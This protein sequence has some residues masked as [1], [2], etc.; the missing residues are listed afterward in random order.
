MRPCSLPMGATALRYCADP[1]WLA[2]PKL[3]GVRCLLAVLEDGCHAWSRQLRPL[4]L[5]PAVEEAARA[6]LPDGAIL[7]C[8]LMKDGTLVAFDVPVLRHTLERRLSMLEEL[9]PHDGPLRLIPAVQF[10]PGV[11]LWVAAMLAGHEGIVLKRRDSMYQWASGPDDETSA[12]MKVRA[13]KA[14]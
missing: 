4:R 5:R 7:D 3:D 2:Q 6:L 10:L 1:R 8:E 14:R 11:P 12:W 9:L 13:I